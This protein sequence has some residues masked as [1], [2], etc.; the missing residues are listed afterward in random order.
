[1]IPTRS[2]PIGSFTTAGS[3]TRAK[4]PS[5][6]RIAQTKSFAPTAAMAPSR[7]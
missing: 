7:M 1:M 6:S 4:N 2:P 3:G 5:A